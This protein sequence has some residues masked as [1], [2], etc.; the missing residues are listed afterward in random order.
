[1]DWGHLS[2]GDAALNAAFTRGGQQYDMIGEEIDDMALDRPVSQ[3]G[4][5]PLAPLGRG[6]GAVQPAW[7]TNPAAAAAPGSDGESACYADFVA[8]TELFCLVERHNR[9]AETLHVA[10]NLLSC[11]VCLAVKMPLPVS[12]T[13]FICMS[14]IVDTGRCA[15]S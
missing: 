13:C 10:I 15:K 9:A 3:G 5:A 6:R 7:M 4:A 2:A 11:K 14:I 8:I 1:M 12:C